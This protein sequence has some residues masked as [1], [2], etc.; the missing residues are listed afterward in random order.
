[1][2]TSTLFSKI[3]GLTTIVR[4][5]NDSVAVSENTQWQTASGT[6]DY[7]YEKYMFVVGVHGALKNSAIIRKSELTLMTNSLQYYLSA[8]WNSDNLGQITFNDNIFG[9][10]A[11]T[12]DYAFD[13]TIYGIK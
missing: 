11:K 2:V 12:K 10:S 9:I 4:L 1:M 13:Y 6:F 5:V 3:D 8:Y 7:T